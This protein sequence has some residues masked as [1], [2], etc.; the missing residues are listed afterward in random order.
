MQFYHQPIMLKEVIEGLDLKPSSFVVDCTVGGGGHSSEILKIIKNGHLLALDKDDDA[1]A[2]C[3][4]RFK[5]FKNVTFAKTD[6][7]DFKNVLARHGIEKV[8]AILVDLGVSSHQ[9]DAAER[10]FSFRFD[11]KLDMRMDKTQTLTAFDVVNTYSKADLSRIIRIYGEERFANQIANNIVAKRKQKP[12]ETT[13]ELKQIIENSIP[14]KFVYK[15]GS[16][17][18][19]QAIRIEV[20]NELNGLSEALNDMID[21]LAPNGRIAVLTFHSLEDRI[22]KEVFR[23]NAKGCICP[24]SAPICICNHKPKLEIINKT[25]ITPTP[26]EQAANPRSTPAKLRLGRGGPTAIMNDVL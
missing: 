25:P 16:K 7:K 24:P 15:G 4:E 19:F 5:D 9:L 21:C 11:G 8:D 2:Y 14:A 23:F 18:T 10:G 13:L 1:L 12:I 20:N 22:V 17:R 6:F 26:S 3:K